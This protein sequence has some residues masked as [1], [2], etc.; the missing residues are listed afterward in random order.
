MDV[1]LELVANFIAV[2]DA[3]HYG[4]A[5]DEL[6][7]S[8][9]ALTKRIQRLELQVG[10]PLVERGTEGLTGLTAAGLEFA[11]AARPLLRQARAV[12]DAA[13]AVPEEGVLRVAIP[14]GTS[15]LLRWLP[16]ADVARQFGQLFPNLRIVLVEVPF[17][18]ITRCLPEG[19]ADVLL[20]V[21]PVQHPEVESGPLPITSARIGVVSGRHLFAG[22]DGVTVAEMCEQRLLYNPDLPE[23]W[24]RPFWFGEL[25]TRAD[26]LLAVSHASSTARVYHDLEVGSLAIVTLSTERDLLPAHLEVVELH[27]APPVTFY[28]ARRRRDRR[29]AADAYIALLRALPGQALT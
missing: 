28:A 19:R 9:S 21:A 18:L 22:A 1:D 20:T 7:L 14:S 17:P 13:R 15:S 29:M 6:F 4:R 27:G 5:A 23:E 11:A 12:A 2:V 26:A 3:W 25:R 16:L 10:L 24:M 8:S